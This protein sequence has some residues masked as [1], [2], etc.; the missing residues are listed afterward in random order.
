[1]DIQAD[2]LVA[3]VVSHDPPFV[4]FELQGV[5]FI[6]A[7][8]LRVLAE[9]QRRAAAAA[10]VVRLAAPSPCVRRFL[11][12]AG[13]T[14]TF[15]VFDIPQMALSTPLNQAGPAGTTSG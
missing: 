3:D 13:S 5:T 11:A 8:G 2:S 6:D 15:S 9:S 7:S 10:G 1:M 14:V 4:V 12:L